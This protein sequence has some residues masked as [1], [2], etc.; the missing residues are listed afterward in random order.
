MYL[1]NLHHSI[2]LRAGRWERERVSNNVYTTPR[3]LKYHQRVPSNK[4]T[5][6]ASLLLLF[7]PSYPR[8]Y[9]GCR[10][11]CAP[12]CRLFCIAVL[13]GEGWRVGV[14]RAPAPLRISQCNLTLMV[15]VS[16]SR[17]IST[18]HYTP[19]KYGLSTIP[20]PSLSGSLG[21]SQYGCAV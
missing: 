10:V 13:S 5:I 8:P 1:N 18:D 19:S 11:T 12:F 4:E 14:I 15:F 7:L 21:S 20:L 17:G 3:L 6:I 9:E 16:L 2:P